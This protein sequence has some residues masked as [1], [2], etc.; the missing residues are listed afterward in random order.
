MPAS[1][2][3][4]VGTHAGIVDARAWSRVQHLDA[5][6]GEGHDCSGIAFSASADR[7]WVGL[8]DYVV[9]YE[10]D[11]VSRRAFGHGSLC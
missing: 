1:R 6:R 11:T 7:L 9:S 4:A 8:D 10:L 3:P 2:S 5:G